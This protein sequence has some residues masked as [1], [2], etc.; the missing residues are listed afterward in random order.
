[1]K[2]IHEKLEALERSQA[3]LFMVSLLA[4]KDMLTVK[5]AA[6]LSGK[7]ERSIR[8]WCSAGQLTYSKPNGKDIYIKKQHLNEFLSGNT[9]LGRDEVK[10]AASKLLKKVAWAY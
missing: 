1:M 7:S 2:H 4:A 8:E 10:D 5:D 3:D 9:T 6:L